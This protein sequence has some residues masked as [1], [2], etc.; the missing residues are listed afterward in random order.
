[1]EKRLDYKRNHH[2]YVIAKLGKLKGTDWAC[3]YFYNRSTKTWTDEATVDTL[4]ESKEALTAY[5]SKHRKECL[6][7]NMRCLWG[8]ME[9]V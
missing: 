1:M 3:Y 5:R 6:G 9:G 4:F 2:F 8:S 7:G